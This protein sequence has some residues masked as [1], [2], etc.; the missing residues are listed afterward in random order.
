M[1]ETAPTPGQ[2]RKVRLKAGHTQTEAAE[3]IGRG[4]R[5]WQYLEQWNDKRREPTPAEWYQYL[6][7]TG[8]LEYYEG[9]A[10]R[11]KNK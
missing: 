9:L 5:Y 2:V 8:M 4:L 11:D 10:K 1:I 6:L 7:V 3:T